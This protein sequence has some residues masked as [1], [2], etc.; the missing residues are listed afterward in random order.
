[1]RCLP[2]LPVAIA[3][4]GCCPLLLLLLEV[5]GL[6]VVL[7]AVVAA[8]FVMR[9][10]PAHLLPPAPTSELLASLLMPPLSAPPLPRP[11]GMTD[12]SATMAGGTTGGTTGG[13]MTGGT[14]GGPGCLLC[15]APL[16][17]GKVTDI[18]ILRRG[19]LAGR[20]AGKHL[21]EAVTSSH[22]SAGVALLAR[23]CL[24]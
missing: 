8:A 6:L 20:Q 4:C 19:G 5:A 17:P 10:L 7:V 24:F 21:F 13:R 3:C 11:A 1:M 2:L 23:L 9:A 22:M 15:C 12:A 14:T 16:M 18:T